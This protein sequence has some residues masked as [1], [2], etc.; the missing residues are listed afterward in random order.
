MLRAYLTPLAVGD[1]RRLW[2]GLFFSMTGTTL[3]NAAILWHVTLLVE[4]EERATAL[5]AVGLARAVPIV[6]CAL[7][8]GV[9]ADSVHR[10]R[11]LVAINLSLLV[12]SSSL[13]VL[14][15]TGSLTVPLFYGLVMLMAGGS[16]FD[17][18]ARNALYP[19]L[20]P[21]HELPKAVLL[22]GAAFQVAA[23]LGPTLAGLAIARYGLASAYGMDALSFVFILW[24]I[25]RIRADGAPPAQE[26][27]SVSWDSALIGLRFVFGHRLIRA[28]MLLDFGAT[29]FGSATALLPLY[30]Q[31]ILKSGPEGYG[32]LSAA[33]AFGSAATSVF[34]APLLE[35]VAHRGK[36]LLASVFAYGAFTCAFAYS[37]S[38]WLSFASLAAVGM[39]DTVSTLVRQLIRQLEAPDRLRGRMAGVNLMFFMG[40]PQLGELEAGL[41]AR[42]AGPELAVFSGG[43]ACAGLV[44]FVKRAAPELWS[45]QRP[46]SPLNESQ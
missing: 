4:T 34:F 18:P 38:F 32:I 35:K 43:I 36:M 17:N 37:R 19:M 13:A 20:I 39:S 33:I 28:S 23:V 21:R 27:A 3:R 29:F 46:N 1:F 41:L 45:Y 5:A 10:K 6:L 42:A 24:S 44:L 30:A 14:T 15:F 11:L 8:A 12:C 16:T 22:V 26:R 25:G 31:D 2:F 7:L 9:L 40:G